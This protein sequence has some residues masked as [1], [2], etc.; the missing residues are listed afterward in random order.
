MFRRFNVSTRNS[1]LTGFIHKKI[2]CRLKL[3][4]SPVHD[5]L[6]TAERLECV[7]CIGYSNAAEFKYRLNR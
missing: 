1:S 4:N 5:T 6:Q 3:A 7:C 2:V